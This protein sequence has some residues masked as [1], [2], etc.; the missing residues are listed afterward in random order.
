MEVFWT[1]C[2]VQWNSCKS[3]LFELDGVDINWEVGAWTDLI[4]LSCSEKLACLHQTAKEIVTSFRHTHTYILRQASSVNSHIMQVNLT[5]S[6]LAPTIIDY[7]WPQPTITASPALP[8][9]LLQQRHTKATRSS[10]RQE[11]T[12]LNYTIY[13]HIQVVNQIQW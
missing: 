1:I 9:W 12:A 2:M 7:Q 8:L 11:N 13:I 5:C 6:H 4:M 3:W 10:E